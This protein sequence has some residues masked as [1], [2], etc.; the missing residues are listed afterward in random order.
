MQKDL[1]HRLLG[2][3][4]NQDQPSSETKQETQL[5]SATI[6]SDALIIVPIRGTVL[7]PQNVAPLVIGRKASIAAVQEAVR[8]EKPVGLIMQLRDKDEDPSPNDLYM[9]GTVAEILRYITAADGTHHIV[10]Q[11]MQRFRVQEFLP[12]YPF[13][14]ARI[15]RYEEADQSNRDIE[16]RVITLK[17]KALEVLA[18]SRQAPAELVNAIQ[19]ISSPTMLADMIASYLISKAEEKQEILR[20]FDIQERIDKILEL[21][22]YQV[23][24]LKLSNKINE[25]TQETMG[26]RQ[27][28]FVLREQMKAIQKELGENARC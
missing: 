28:E 2:A 6:P 8:S 25:Q 24:V 11:G 15:E 12:G 4:A 3:V 5:Q 19:T 14:V 13:L 16:A 26:Q 21:L 18:H 23:E 27:R 17:Q 10:C 20:L 22:N 9:V 7:F 1:I